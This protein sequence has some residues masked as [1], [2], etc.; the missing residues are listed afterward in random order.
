MHKAISLRLAVALAVLGGAMTAKAE[1]RVSGT[2][3]AIVVQTKDATLADVVGGVAAASHTRIELNG[4]PARQFTG[5]YSGSL[6]TVLSRLLVGVDHVVHSTGDRITIVIVGPNAAHSAAVA[7]DDRGSPVQGWMP[8]RSQ[9]VIAAASAPAADDAIEAT[10][11]VQGWV[12]TKV[13]VASNAA[14]PE[15]PSAPPAPAPTDADKETSGVQGWMPTSVAGRAQP[16]P[17]VAVTPPQD[18]PLASD[19]GAGS[20]V[21]GWMPT[22]AHAN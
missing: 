18:P 1:V 21:Q 4:A 12:P 7:R 8:T 9:V 10:S 16:A 6:R 20:G 17:V 15:R 19:D 2:A 14:A 5:T 3:D 22:A 13:Q 11:S